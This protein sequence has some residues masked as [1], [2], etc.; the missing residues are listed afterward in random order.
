MRGIFSS[1]KVIHLLNHLQ[2]L[3]N[4]T[5]EVGQFWD[6][7]L[8]LLLEATGAEAGVFCLCDSSKEWRT[9]AYYPKDKGNEKYL[10]RFL[11]AIDSCSKLCAEKGSALVPAA[12]Y[13]L[14]GCPVLMDAKQGKALFLASLPNAPDINPAEALHTCVSLSDLYA[15]YHIRQSINNTMALQANLTSIFEITGMVNAAPRFL[16]A[17]MTLVNEL[18]N[19]NH[20]ERVSLG[21]VKKGYVKITVLSHTDT[22]EKKMDIVRDLENAMEEAMEQDS[23]ISFPMPPD[24]RLVGRA[25]EYYHKNH[26]TGFLL[27]IPLRQGTDFAGI[28]T[29]ERTQEPFTESETNRLQLTADQVT[30]KLVELHHH[31]RWFGAKIAGALRKALAKLLGY[32]Y[33]W[34]KLL[35]LLLAAFLLFA[36]FV[37]ISYRVDAPAILLTDKIMFITAPF[38][39][40]IDSVFVKPG[41]ILQKGQKILCLDKKQFLLEEADYL[42][43]EQNYL[44]EIQKAQAAGELAQ[45]RISQAKLEQTQAKLKTTRFK[46]S[47]SVI[48]SPVDQA[49]V[50]DGDLQKRLGAPVSLGNELFQIALIE[51]I[52]VAIDVDEMEIENVRQGTEGVVAIKSRPDYVYRFQVVRIHPSATVKAEENTFQ[53]RGEFVRQVPSWFRPGMTG[54]AKIESGKRTLWWILTHRAIDIL[55]LKLWW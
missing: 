35:C 17:A 20:C 41:D 24:S 30:P 54:V 52:Y 42:A 27:S 33:T 47:Q 53:V 2:A 11:S 1:D 16:S 28:V 38:D 49:V 34:I 50:V 25:H 19:R 9:L 43:E 46:L 31:D 44:R 13:T 40:Y 3:R 55:R 32:E 22:F 21:W 18:A 39:G 4:F 14:L 29:F 36:V 12:E 15:Q 51:N 6:Q 48:R 26:D 7:Y 45:M 8:V 5:G 23:S 10:K 37:P